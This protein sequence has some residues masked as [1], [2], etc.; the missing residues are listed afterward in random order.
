MSAVGP[1]AGGERS[2]HKGDHG[3][4]RWG[5]SSY[6][7]TLLADPVAIG[8]AYIHWEGFDSTWD[9]WVSEESVKLTGPKQ[10]GVTGVTPWQGKDYPCT[11][12]KF[13]TKEFVKVHYDEYS[14]VWDEMVDY[15]HFV[16]CNAAPA[17]IPVVANVG[18]GPKGEFR[19]GDRG[20]WRWGSSKS[21]VV[22]LSDPTSLP[23]AL[24][25]WDGFDS[26]WDSWVAETAIKFAGKKEEGARGTTPWQGRD[27]DCTVIKLETRELVMIHYA[28][29]SDGVWDERVDYRKFVVCNT[30]ETGETGALASS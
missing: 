7:V 29:D 16:S 15:R 19:R 17:P 3:D 28:G 30:S 18:S 10:E 20:Q 2:F 1:Q 14:D 13:D 23:A 8:A 4:W 9:S 12:M 25:H 27:F 6:K 5:S 24:I 26:N 11:V 21:D 22:L